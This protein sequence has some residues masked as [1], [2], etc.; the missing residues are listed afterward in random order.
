MNHSVENFGS[1]KR[2]KKALALDIKLIFIKIC[3]GRKK[4]SVTALEEGLSHLTI[5]TIIKDNNRIQE[6]KV[7]GIKLTMLEE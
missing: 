6:S 7:R 5:L 1:T 4:V 2:V 3:Y